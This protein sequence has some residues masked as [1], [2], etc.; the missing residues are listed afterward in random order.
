VLVSQSCSTDGNCNG[1]KC[2]ADKT[3]DCTG[4]NNSGVFC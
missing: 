3:C 4:T 1:G 2:K